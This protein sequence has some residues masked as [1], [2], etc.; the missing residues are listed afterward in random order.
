MPRSS[1]PRLTV[2]YGRLGMTS[3][4]DF[5]GT[6]EA[7]PFPSPPSRF[8]SAVPPGLT[9]SQAYPGLASWAVIFPPLRG[10]AASLS[11]PQWTSR[12]KAE[13]RIRA[14]LFS[15]AF[16]PNEEL[17][18]AGWRARAPAP[19]DLT[20]ASA[21][22]PKAPPADRGQSGSSYLLH[23][24]RRIPGRRSSR[25]KFR[26]CLKSRRPSRRAGRSHSSLFAGG[27]W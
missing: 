3:L 25:N 21:P 19:H 23:R 15:G 14:R 5:G 20:P 7:V 12:S 6:A 11:A 22:P 17:E 8:V 27:L 16:R 4:E 13:V 10:C 1:T 18:G 26:T 2:G 24:R 9:R